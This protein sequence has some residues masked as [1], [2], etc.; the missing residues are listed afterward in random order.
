MANILYRWALV[1]AGLLA[2]LTPAFGE[3]EYR[4]N[5]AFFKSSHPDSERERDYSTD[6]S[7]VGASG[8]VTGEWLRWGAGM[9]RNSHSRWGP[10]AGF[11][12]TFAFAEGWRAGLNAGLAGNYSSNGWLRAGALPIVQ[13]KQPESELIWEFG[14][15]HRSDAT[16]AGVGVHIPFSVLATK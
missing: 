4:V 10:Y 12:G 16:F 1:A 3:S 6:H 7:S 14:F 8:P 2:G 13:W 9:V 5:L 15:I 11:T